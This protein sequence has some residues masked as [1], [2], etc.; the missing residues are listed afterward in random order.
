MKL[1]SIKF[2]KFLAFSLAGGLF[3]SLPAAVLCCMVFLFFLI[4]LMPIVFILCWFMGAI[5]GWLIAG[6]ERTLPIWTYL[7]NI[8]FSVIISFMVIHI[9]LY[10]ND[11][12]W[13]IIW[14]SLFSCVFAAC[15]SPAIIIIKKE[16][17][18][19]IFIPPIPKNRPNG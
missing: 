14:T 7:C 5:C 17:I 16:I 19:E 2:L 6:T 4:P 12:V 3:S 8:G 15:S 11:I 1:N 18:P 10:P 13:C 9:W